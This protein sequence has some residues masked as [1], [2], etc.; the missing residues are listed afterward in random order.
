MAEE[1]VF[2]VRILLPGLEAIRGLEVDSECMPMR[3]RQ[4]G[5]IDM[6]AIIPQATLGKLRRM[7]R[8]NVS[9]EILAGPGLADAD[10]EASARC[11]APT[12][13]PTAPFRVGWEVEEISHVSQC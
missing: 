2:R 4:D 12:V 10:R 9:V 1:K 13:M 11:R 6:E 5:Q 8:R 3:R 7:R